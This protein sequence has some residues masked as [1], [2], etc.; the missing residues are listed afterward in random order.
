MKKEIKVGDKVTRIMA[1]M[2][3]SLIVTDL[4]EFFIF[5]GDWK[6]D[7][8]TGVEI[9]EELGWDNEGSGSYLKELR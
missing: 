3:M 7:R 5:C 6:F 4:S 2:K 8:Q 1:G 9:Y